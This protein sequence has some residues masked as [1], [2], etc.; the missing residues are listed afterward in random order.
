M[1]IG[2]HGYRSSQVPGDLPPAS[3]RPRK[4]GGVMQS[5]PEGLGIR[6]AHGVCEGRRWDEM[7]PLSSEAGKKGVNSSFLCLLLSSGPWCSG[8]C[9]PQCGSAHSNAILPRNTLRDTPEIMFGLSIHWPGRLTHKL[10]LHRVVYFEEGII[11]F[12]KKFWTR[13]WNSEALVQTTEVTCISLWSKSPILRFLSN[14]M[15]HQY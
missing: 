2:S 1:R 8:G 15:G 5:E 7:A 10:N 12:W 3:W 13:T 9:P 11:L 6:K 4:A 14:E